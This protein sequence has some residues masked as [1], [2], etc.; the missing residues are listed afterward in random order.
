MPARLGVR[1]AP[2]P[3]VAAH[4]VDAVRT[5]AAL[6][7]VDRSRRTDPVLAHIALRRSGLVAPGIHI[8]ARTASRFLPLLRSGERLAC[9]LCV[10]CGIFPGHEDNRVIS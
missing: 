10:R 3:D 1:Q 8:A 6:V 2:F 9:P 4:V 7:T 5:D